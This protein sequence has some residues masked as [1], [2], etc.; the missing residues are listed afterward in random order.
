[1][2]SQ[3]RVGLPAVR[4]LA[5]ILTLVQHDTDRTA[6][7]RVFFYVVLDDQERDARS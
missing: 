3:G 1:V 5:K 6:A 4:R 7:S 2:A